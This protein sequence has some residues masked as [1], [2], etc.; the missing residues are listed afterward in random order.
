[1]WNFKTCNSTCQDLWRTFCVCTM[2][3]VIK[4]GKG[5]CL[6]PLGCYIPCQ[7]DLGSSSDSNPNSGFQL[8]YAMHGSSE[9]GLESLALDLSLAQ[10]LI[11]GEQTSEW[12]VPN[13]FS[14]FTLQINFEK[15]KSLISLTLTC[16]AYFYYSR[17]WQFAVA[18]QKFFKS[19]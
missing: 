4:V 19:K 17:R 9:A 18:F 2:N 5:G 8:M 1:M 12:E 3:F 6:K 7:D 14:L 16:S 13:S 15:S 11:Y 10:P